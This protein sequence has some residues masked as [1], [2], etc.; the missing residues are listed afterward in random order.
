MVFPS[1]EALKPKRGWVLELI[2]AK[3]GTAQFLAPDVAYADV[4]KYLPALPL[5]LLLTS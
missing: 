3:A 1:P 4:R 5:R 2:A